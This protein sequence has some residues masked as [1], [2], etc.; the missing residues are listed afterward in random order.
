M[1]TSREIRLGRN[2]THEPKHCRTLPLF[3]LFFII[4]QQTY[5]KFLYLKFYSPQHRYQTDI[6]FSWIVRCWREK[7]LNCNDIQ[8]FSHS[9]LKAKQVLCR[10]NGINTRTPPFSL[11]RSKSSSEKTFIDRLRT[12]IAPS[13]GAEALFVLLF[14]GLE[15]IGNVDREYREKHHPRS[16]KYH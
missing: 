10:V 1:R 6:S 4:R 11:S 14:P 15:F 8:S 12:I 3:D 2:D 9:D 7:T 16:R 5:K 13:I